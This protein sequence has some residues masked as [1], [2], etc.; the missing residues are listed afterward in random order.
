VIQSNTPTENFRTVS[1]G[2]QRARAWAFLAL[3]G[4]LSRCSPAIA[5]TGP[6][7]MFRWLG[8]FEAPE[9][10]EIIANYLRGYLLFGRNTRSGHWFHWYTLPMRSVITRATARVPKNK[11]RLLNRGDFEFRYNQ[12]V[13]QIMR[14]CQQG[15]DGWLT[16]QAVDVYLGLRRLGLV[17]SV[18][19]YRE[20]KLIGGF[21]GLSIGHVFAIMSMFHLESNTGSMALASLCDTVSHGGQWSIIDCGGPGDHWSRHGAENL[22]VRQFSALVTRQLCDAE[23]DFNYSRWTKNASRCDDACGM[24]AASPLESTE[25]SSLHL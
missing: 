2:R 21:W 1:S 11:Q 3:R 13:E 9:P 5:G 18:G 10:A 14:G 25:E 16:E 6:E 19:T 23:Q 12:D 22:T 24:Y 17:A 7:W 4:I 15:R 20:G 8:F